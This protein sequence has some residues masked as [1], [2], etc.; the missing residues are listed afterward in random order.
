MDEIAVS[1]FPIGPQQH[2]PARNLEA[3]PL[4]DYAGNQRHLDHHL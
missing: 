1:F 2:T 3:P 4:R